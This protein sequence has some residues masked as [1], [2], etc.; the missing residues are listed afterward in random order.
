MDEFEDLR[1]C[2]LGDEDDDY[3][4]GS[5]VERA[6]DDAFLYEDEDQ[7]I[8]TPT[9]NSV[10]ENESERAP[11]LI[12]EEEE[13]ERKEEPKKEQ[14]RFISTNINHDAYITLAIA[15]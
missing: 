8:Y 12:E 5:E 7:P 6:P 13:E 1:G 15:A 11:S 9:S 4:G 2:G 3:R 14:V 10:F